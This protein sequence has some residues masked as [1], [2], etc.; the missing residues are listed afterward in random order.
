VAALLITFVALTSLINTVFAHAP[1]VAGQPLSVERILGW[2]FRP[3]VF[4]TGAP[5]A[6]CA[7]LGTLL[8]KKMFLNEFLAFLDLK[9]A[10]TTLSP[11]SVMLATYF[12]CGFAN[13]SAVAMQIG[14]F[15]AIF[16]EKRDL[17]A[18]FGLKS[19][20]GGT[21]ASLLSAC[22]AGTLL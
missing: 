11:R 17:I 13:F 3:I 5:W 2:I 14:G 20:L 21:L 1:A 7:T 8:G 18:E 15:S 6:D 10:M 22:I 16:P 19:M 4:L 12:L 9:S